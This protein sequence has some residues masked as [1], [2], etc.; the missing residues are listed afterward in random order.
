MTEK[1]VSFYKYQPISL[2]GCVWAGNTEEIMAC[3][4]HQKGHNKKI[5][6]SRWFENLGGIHCSF[7]NKSFFSHSVKFISRQMLNLYIPKARIQKQTSFFPNY[8]WRNWYHQKKIPAKSTYTRRRTENSMSFKKSSVAMAHPQ[9]H[10][11]WSQYPLLD[12]SPEQAGWG[13]R[14]RWYQV[15]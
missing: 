9:E 7:K 2:A 13:G 10:R 12:T 11:D 8:L 15:S 1:Q 4:Y 5:C 6:F 14:I 3:S